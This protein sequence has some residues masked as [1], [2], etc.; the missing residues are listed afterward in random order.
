MLKN[1]KKHWSDS[2]GLT[3][4]KFMHHAMMKATKVIIQATSHIIF[5]CDGLYN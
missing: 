4:A 1:N 3:M 2:L 5:S